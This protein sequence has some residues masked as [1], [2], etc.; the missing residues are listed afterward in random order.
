MSLYGL[1]F[2]SKLIGIEYPPAVQAIDFLVK[3]S[4][5]ES[6]TIIGIILGCK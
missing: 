4:I 6:V 1:Y 5:F 3:I 2:K